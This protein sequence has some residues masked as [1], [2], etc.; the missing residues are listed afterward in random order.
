MEVT[1][2]AVIGDF[3][4][5][6][7]LATGKEEGGMS[8]TFLAHE[9]VRPRYKVVLKMNKSIGKRASDYQNLLK[10]EA[11]MLQQL[12]HPNIVRIYP[13]RARRSPAYFA[14]L[15]PHDQAP[16]YY[17]ME[18]IPE[19]SL[20]FY[21]PHIA[22]LSLEWRIELFY[23]L[24]STVHYMHTHDIAHG[25]IKPQNILF[26]TP[27][28]ES[29]FPTP[30]IID[31]GS[32]S[33]VSGVDNLTASL[34]YSPPEILDAIKQN[35]L[36]KSGIRADKVDIW[37]LGVV[38]F[39]IVTGKLFF[40]ERSMHAIT[41]TMRSQRLKQIRDLLPDVHKSLDTYMAR[42]VSINPQR[43][44]S[45]KQLLTGLEDRIHSARAPRIAYR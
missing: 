6:E 27:P 18:Y 14:R 16:W 3:T 28:R 35:Q 4:I 44:P 24:L 38:L 1:Q 32:A 2:G 30:V 22:R 41:T 17:L 26:R 39:E 36:P 40:H 19:K 23:Q 11:S 21:K 29:E 15:I 5:D 34:R 45:T 31:F 7:E 8:Q 33:P 9:T 10:R 42:M 25:D 37:S 12:R 13:I 43:R 20:E